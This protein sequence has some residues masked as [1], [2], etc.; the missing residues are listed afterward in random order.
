[1]SFWKLLGRSY[2][3]SS[4]S[5]H[6]RHIENITL[7]CTLQLMILGTWF[8]TRANSL[9]KS[10]VNIMN[11]KLTKV[12]EK[13]TV[14]QKSEPALWRKLHEYITFYLFLNTSHKILKYFF[15]QTNSVFKFQLVLVVILDNFCHNLFTF[16][17][18]GYYLTFNSS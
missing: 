11:Q 15:S 8:N 6:V 4:F 12:P 9:I 13:F 7:K 16:L 10:W 5:T 3:Q 2:V 1:M 18:F 14:A 17:P